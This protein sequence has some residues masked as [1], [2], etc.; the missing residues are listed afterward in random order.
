M[1]FPLPSRIEDLNRFTQVMANGDPEPDIIGYYPYLSYFSKKYT[2][3]RR[4]LE[5]Y[6]NMCFSTPHYIWYLSMIIIFIYI[7]IFVF[8]FFYL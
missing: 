5:D 6:L 7:C 2:I 4:N 3:L 8:I 1:F